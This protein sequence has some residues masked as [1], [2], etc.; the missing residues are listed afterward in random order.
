MPL[1]SGKHKLRIEALHARR[2][3]MGVLGGESRGEINDGVLRRAPKRARKLFACDRVGLIDPTRA[4]NAFEKAENALPNWEIYAFVRCDWAPT[5]EYDGSQAIVVFYSDHLF[6]STVPNQL[7]AHL[8]RFAWETLAEAY[9]IGDG[10]SYGGT[11]S[12]SR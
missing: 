11:I 6:E 10:E 5:D 7:S 8:E 3:Y 2:A 12:V 1:R 9:R 4:W